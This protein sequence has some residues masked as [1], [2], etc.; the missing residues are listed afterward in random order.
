MMTS[1]INIGGLRDDI[2]EGFQAGVK[3]FLQYFPARLKDY[4]ALL[5]N[6][7][8]WLER[9]K[10]VGYLSLEDALNY[11]VTGPL[12]R[13]AGMEW[14]VRKAWPYGGYEEFDFDIPTGEN[15]DV[16]DRYLVRMEEMRQSLRIVE[17]ALAKIT[18]GAYRIEDYKIVLPPRQRLDVSMESL[19]HHFLVSTE[20]FK[21]PAGDAYVSVEGPRGETGYYI[22]SD[23]GHK[24]YR[25]HMRPASFSALQAFPA[26]AKGHLVADIIAIMGSIDMVMGEVD[27]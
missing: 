17:Q 19:I 8:I 16:Y 22:V 2:P 9:T 4:H 14:D 18:P 23:G 3:D 11:G 27:R 15:S 26:M 5:T 6:N 1:Y 21:V 12:L 10:G 13:A 25:V 24:P 7:P 20:G